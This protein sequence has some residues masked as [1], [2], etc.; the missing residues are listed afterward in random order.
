[1]EF[2]ERWTCITLPGT[3]VRTQ[4]GWAGSAP[5]TLIGYEDGVNLYRIYNLSQYVDCIRDENPTC[6]GVH[7]LERLYRWDIHGFELPGHLRN[8][9]S[10]NDLLAPWSRSWCLQLEEQP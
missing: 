9:L 5:K 7:V 8:I 2:D 10:R 4:A 6:S 1:V 3:H